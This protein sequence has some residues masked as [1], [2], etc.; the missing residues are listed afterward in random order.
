[1]IQERS[2]PVLWLLVVGVWSLAL[3]CAAL[4]V[5]LELN[6]TDFVWGDDL[7]LTAHVQC[8]D[9]VFWEQIYLFIQLPGVSANPAGQL[10]VKYDRIYLPMG[11]YWGPTMMNYCARPMFENVMLPAGQH[12][13]VLLEGSLA[14]VVPMVSGTGTYSFGLESRTSTYAPELLASADFSFRYPE[15]HPQLFTF[16]NPGIHAGFAELG[17]SVIVSTGEWYPTCHVGYEVYNYWDGGLYR[18]QGDTVQ[19]LQRPARALILD[20]AVDSAGQTWVTY[21][22][23]LDWTY[24][25]GG[26]VASVG[27]PSATANNE[28]NEGYRRWRSPREGVYVSLSRTLALLD[29]LELKDCWEMTEAIPGV[30]VSMTSAPDARVFLVSGDRW[31]NPIQFYLSWW[32]SRGLDS[33]QSVNINT[34]LGHNVEIWNYPKFG[35]DGLVYLL[36]SSETQHA[37]LRLNPEAREWRLFSCQD[38]PIDCDFEFFYIDPLDN[39]WFGSEG[40]LAQFDG[41]NWSDYWTEDGWLRHD[42]IIQMQYDK[43]DGVYYV[44]TGEC[45]QQEWCDFA[46]T[47]FYPFDLAS[48]RHVPFPRIST[49]YLSWDFL[50]T[51]F[52]G[53][54]SSWWL[55]PPLNRHEIYSYDHSDTLR[56][57]FR[58]WFHDFHWGMFEGYNEYSAYRSFSEFTRFVGA[59]SDGRTFCVSDKSVIIW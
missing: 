48:C 55:S 43:T 29:G 59:T 31:S 23:G 53:A 46:L 20:G 6:R 10:Y 34:L 58:D 22:K 39:L 57:D 45:A 33:L 13:F 7:I 42:E 27:S 26:Q 18:V 49:Y 36:V 40:R 4:T 14:E 32:D 17:G 3:G 28:G 8:E 15:S 2:R 5:E 50:P 56:W 35:S 51:V 47:F 19:Q 44:V 1:M 24:S 16:Q 12:S 30:I 9:S 54:G 38:C 52:S 21:G 41:E 25:W 37:V 11:E